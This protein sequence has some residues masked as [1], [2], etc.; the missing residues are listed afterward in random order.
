MNFDYELYINDNPLLG[1]V[2]AN[3]RITIRT[4][5]QREAYKVFISKLKAHYNT[6]S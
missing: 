5:E 3:G 6:E 2:L 1:Y 4:K